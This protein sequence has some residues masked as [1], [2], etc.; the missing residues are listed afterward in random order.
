MSS[1]PNRLVLHPRPQTTRYNSLVLYG[2]GA[3]A[4]IVVLAYVMAVHSHRP[5]AQWERPAHFV[6]VGRPLIP[7]VEKPPPPPPPPPQAMP[8]PLPQP[9]LTPPPPPH[10]EDPGAAQ[11]KATLV[12][13][14]S[15]PVI[16]AEFSADAQ[17]REPGRLSSTPATFQPENSP[18]QTLTIPP[19]W[20]QQTDHPWGGYPG[21]VGRSQQFWQQSS[22]ATAE[23]WLAANVM[24]PRSPYQINAGTIIPA[25]LA[26]AINSDV[27]GQAA[28]IVT[29]NIYDSATGRYLLVPQGARVVGFYDND[30]Q[31]HQARI[32]I[33]WKTLYFPN[34][35]SLAL[36]G[37]PGADG[38]GMAGLRDQ[39]DRHSLQRYGTA[40]LLSAITAGIT[41]GTYRGQGFFTYD[42]GEAATYGLGR[43]FGGA[44]AEDLR[45]GMSTRPTILV[46]EG[47]PF[48]VMVAQ[49]VVFRG[50]YP[51]TMVTAQDHV[52]SGVDAVR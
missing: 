17:H 28:A 24:P 2:V 8:E 36:H 37:M 35:F 25:V 29:Q 41:L 39:M 49:D 40:L 15:K 42:P 33:A 1:G 34:G 12:K 7:Q 45:R 5:Q 23:Q 13:A 3:V 47:Y 18:P 6:S 11:R 46:R 20:G 21:P 26:S 22:G 44:I 4:V 51:F 9:N 50:P 27:E 19:V 30:L 52:P 10:L 38:A 32:G 31:P 48:N 43:T 14:L 16:V